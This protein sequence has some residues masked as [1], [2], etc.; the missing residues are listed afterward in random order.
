MPPKDHFNLKDPADRAAFERQE[1]LF[2]RVGISAMFALVALVGTQLYSCSHNSFTAEF[3]DMNNA[4]RCL[5]DVIENKGKLRLPLPQWRDGPADKSTYVWLGD[6]SAKAAMLTPEIVQQCETLTGVKR[7][8]AW[9]RL[10]ALRP[11]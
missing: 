11:Q 5:A 1:R 9:D 7:S 6:Q 10:L 3:N 2:R 8:P 4:D